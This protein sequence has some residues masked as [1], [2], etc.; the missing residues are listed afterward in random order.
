[1]PDSATTTEKI[2]LH[3]GCGSWRE[4]ALHP[5]YCKPGW[6]EVRLDID[7]KAK[8]DVVA[9]ITDMSVVPSESVDAIWT[10]H[11]LEHLAAHEVPIALG[12]FRRTL[13]KGGHVFMRV[14]DVEIAAEMIIQRGILSTA[15]TSPSGPITPLDMLFGHSDLIAKGQTHMRHKT[16]FTRDS[17][18]ALLTEAQFQNVNAIRDR[19]DVWARG[20]R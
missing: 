18:V 12:E 3:V 13:R 16:A 14:P 7:P 1:M 9:S 17:I 4:N 20:E 8:P 2:V 15:Y 5:D 11:T 6:R 10:S 19:F